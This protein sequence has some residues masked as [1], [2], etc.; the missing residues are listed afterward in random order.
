MAILT[1]RRA[2]LLVVG[3]LASA[4]IGA[5]K[6]RAG[7][8]HSEEA[9]KAAFL[10]RF[11]GYIDWPRDALG[12]GQFTIA[13]LGDPD[14]EYQLERLVP[15]HPIKNLPVQVRQ[16]RSV[17]ELG[18]AQVLFVGANHADD[19]HSLVAAL[20]KRPV[21]VVT[22]SNRGLQEGGSVN[23]LVVD[24][25]VRFEVSLAAADQAGLRIGSELLSVALHVAGP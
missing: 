2:A 21:L 9:V 15:G 8:A 17:R 5:S 13:V 12:S 22:D 18:N 25:R 19:I 16:I 3:A 7:E 20:G 14:V 1:N 11:T 24:R 6:G 23:F 4:L 10:V